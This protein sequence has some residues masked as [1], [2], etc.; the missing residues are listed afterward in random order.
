MSSNLTDTSLILN[1]TQEIT[2]IETTLNQSDTEIPTGKAIIDF[3]IEKGIWSSPPAII[4]APFRLT[5]GAT[6]LTFIN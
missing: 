3:L 1:N 4:L 6:T 5:T 2:G